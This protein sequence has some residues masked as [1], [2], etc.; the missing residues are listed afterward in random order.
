[1]EGSLLEIV[2]LGFLWQNLLKFPKTF[3]FENKV[4]LDAL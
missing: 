4:K 2:G 3:E 1:M